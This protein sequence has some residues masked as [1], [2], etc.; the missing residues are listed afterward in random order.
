MWAMNMWMVSAYGGTAPEEI[1]YIMVFV[2]EN[3]L[4]L[5]E[6]VNCSASAGQP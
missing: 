3:S 4:E 5:L 1:G 6:R 2:G